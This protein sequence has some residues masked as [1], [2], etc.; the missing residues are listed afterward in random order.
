MSMKIH[1]AGRVP[2]R[3]GRKKQLRNFSTYPIAQGHL[4]CNGFLFIIHYSTSHE[5]PAA[6]SSV[7]ARKIGVPRSCVSA[8]S[9]FPLFS[10]HCEEAAGM[11]E[12]HL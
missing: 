8:S 2:N 5:A 1:N 10:C 3:V 11:P 6:V 7:L 12:M 4:K 9:C